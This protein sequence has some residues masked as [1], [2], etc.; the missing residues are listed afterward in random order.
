[1]SDFQTTDKSHSTHP[2]LSQQTTSK[3]P[4]AEKTPFKINISNLD[5]KKPAK[6]KKGRPKKKSISKKASSKKTKSKAKPKKKKK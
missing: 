5:L 1:M 6:K 3:P 4:S 2:L